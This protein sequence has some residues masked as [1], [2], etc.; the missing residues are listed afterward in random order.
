[1][2]TNIPTGAGPTNDVL[3]N[4]LLEATERG[5]VADIDEHLGCLNCEDPAGRLIF[6]GNVDGPWRVDVYPNLDAALDGR[7]PTESDDLQ[8]FTAA[9]MFAHALQVAGR[10]ATE[11]R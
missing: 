9:T 4:L 11:G 6:I 10:V 8:G 5:L 2:T 1:M 7:P 3:R